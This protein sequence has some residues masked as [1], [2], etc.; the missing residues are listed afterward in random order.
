MSEGWEALSRPASEAL[1]RDSGAETQGE[2]EPAAGTRVHPEPEDCV[3]PP[4]AV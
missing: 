3:G 2:P 4:R 1:S